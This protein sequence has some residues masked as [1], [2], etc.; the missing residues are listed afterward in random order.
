MADH[1]DSQALREQMQR[2]RNRMTTEAEV[3]KVEPHRLLDWRW[4]VKQ[5]PWLCVGTAAALGF[6][7]VPGHRITPTVKLDDKSIEELLQ[8]GAVRVQPVKKQTSLTR[9][10]LSL[11][12]TMALKT[13]WN[14]YGPQLM[15]QF[16]GPAFA[17]PAPQP[18]RQPQEA[19]R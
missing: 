16:A 6:W 11:A 8:K 12:A 9:S 13:A 1:C 7:L 4:Y 17:P 2:I 19:R 15:A 14:H 3:L 18:I 10:L 5:S